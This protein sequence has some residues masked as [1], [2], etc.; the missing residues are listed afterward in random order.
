MVPCPRTRPSTGLVRTA[1]LLLVL[2][3]CG[4]RE[5]LGPSTPD[6]PFAPTDAPPAAVTNVWLTKTSM[7]TARSG[8]AAGVVNGVIYVIG[9]ANG[10]SLTTVEAYNPSTNTW[11]TKAPLPKGLE[12]LNG[13]GVING[14]LYVAGGSSA[15]V[16]TLGL[17]AYSPSTNTWTAKTG[18]PSGSSC[19]ASGVIA[20]K[21]YVFNA[22]ACNGGV[23]ALMR[24]DPAANR[25]TTL[26]NT[27][28]GT[29]WP[30]RG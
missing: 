6:V 24:Y 22:G 3:A 2:A 30:P 21:L 17:Y 27:N 26:S 23:G 28:A 14:V 29:A 7:P 25:W 10:P 4:G 19:G 5:V 1:A 12:F 20:G 16:A 18:M 15:G 8:L 13:T 11:A 9:G